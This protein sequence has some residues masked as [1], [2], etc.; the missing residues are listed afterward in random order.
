MRSLPHALSTPCALLQ[1]AASEGDAS[2]LKVWAMQDLG[3]QAS[4]R[5]S[6]SASPLKTLRDIC[7]NFPFSARTLSKL[8]VNRQL[9][10]EVSD[11][12]NMVTAARIGT[13]SNPRTRRHVVVAA[14]ALLPRSALLQG[15]LL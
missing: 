11:A 12:Q 13:A 2:S 3:V 6:S 14:H 15:A 5:V 9:A 1:V 4:S 7:Q 10:Q 8:P